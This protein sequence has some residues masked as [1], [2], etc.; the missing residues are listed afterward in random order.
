M[1]NSGDR[2]ERH[3]YI[4]INYF[5]PFRLQFSVVSNESTNLHS[6]ISISIPFDSLTKGKYK[7]QVVV[8]VVILVVVE[9]KKTHIVYLN[10]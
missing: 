10:V 6:P 1:A 7:E 9:E 4:S 3:K 2:S 8:V 5:K